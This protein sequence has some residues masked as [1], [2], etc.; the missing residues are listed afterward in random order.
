MSSTPVLLEWAAV[1]S[2]PTPA[3][4]AAVASA[5]G[6]DGLGLIL[7]RGVP[8]YAAARAACLPQAFAFGALPAPTKAR[9]EHAAS[10]Y[11]FGWSH[12]RERFAGAPDTAK[13]SFYANP[14]HDAPEPSPAVYSQPQLLPFLHPNIWPSEADAPGFEAA[15]KALSRLMVGAGSALAAHVDALVARG[16]GDADAG[17]G[18][19]RASLEAV[20]RDSRTHKA[21]LLYYFPSEGEG[22]A[23]AAPW[24]GAHNVSVA[25]RRQ[26]ALALPLPPPPRT[27][28]PPSPAPAP[29]PHHRHLVHTPPR[30][31]TTAP[32]PR[33]PRPC[34]VT[35]RARRCPA[36][37]PPRACTSSR[38]R[39]PRCAWPSPRTAW[40]SRWASARRS[41][42]AACSWPRRTGCARPRAARAC[43]G[44]RCVV[45]VAAAPRVKPP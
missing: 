15:F 26:K 42:R 30:R 28:N 31:R 22:G 14:L 27:H 13:G 29:T 17:A 18:A 11:S 44:A 34:T 7:V 43:P 24:C 2:P 16:G 19:P 5:F 1:S 12:G 35:R 33:S 37:T 4:I 40:P 41:P 21:R 23:S 20:V 36:A 25:R 45:C 39:A 9:Y 38:A 32:S 10:L 6:H 8:G 3:T